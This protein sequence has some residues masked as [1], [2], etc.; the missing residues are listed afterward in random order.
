MNSR[1]LKNLD[2]SHRDEPKSSERAKVSGMMN[3]AQSEAQS[4]DTVIKMS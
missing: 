3:I 2:K 4:H 1:I